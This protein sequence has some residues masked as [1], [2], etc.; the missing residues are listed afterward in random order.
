MVGIEASDHFEGHRLL[1]EDALH[2]VF[3]GPPTEAD[4]ADTGYFSQAQARVL[5]LEVD[6]EAPYGV[7]GSFR[8]L[9]VSE[10][11]R[12]SIPSVSKRSILR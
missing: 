11:K 2:G 3:A 1:F 12:L 9:A 7:G 10:S 6:D 4:V 5:R 8:C